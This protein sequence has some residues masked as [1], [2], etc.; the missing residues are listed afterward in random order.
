MR[1]QAKCESG[2][3]SRETEEKE[4]RDEAGVSLAGSEPARTRCG[5]DAVG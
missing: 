2:K 3:T 4:E 1:E 5:G